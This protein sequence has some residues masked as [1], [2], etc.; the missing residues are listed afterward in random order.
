MNNDSFYNDE[1]K[2]MI[3]LARY[4]SMEYEKQ[5]H[6]MEWFARWDLPEEI[7]MEWIDAK[8]IIFS[9]ELAQVISTESVH[10]LVKI[11]NNFELAFTDSKKKDVWTDDAMYKHPFWA[12]QRS[13]AKQF[14]ESVL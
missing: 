1:L 10:L 7:G 13:L 11:L 9:K 2:Y 8:G 6:E 12:E 14:L 3:N 4:L 5:F